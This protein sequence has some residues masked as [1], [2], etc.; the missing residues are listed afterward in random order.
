MVKL[1]LQHTDHFECYFDLSSKTHTVAYSL[2]ETWGSDSV[3]AR[4]VCVHWIMMKGYS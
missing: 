3:T 1:V 2:R 4:A